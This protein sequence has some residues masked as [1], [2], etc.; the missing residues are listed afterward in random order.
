MELSELTEYACE[1]YQI[2]EQHKWADFPGFSVLCH[3]KTGKWVAL[4]MRQWDTDAGREIE[5]CDLKCGRESLFRLARPYL[6]API[7]MRGSKWIGI[8]F[9]EHTESDIV[10]QLFDKAIA[11]AEPQG[12][13]LILGAQPSSDAGTYRDTALPFSG[14]SYRPPR[15]KLPKR[16]WEMKRLYKYGSEALGARAENFYRQAVFMQDYEDDMP[17]TGDFV[18][19]FPTYQDLTTRQLRGYFA[20]RTQLRRGNYQRIA[21]S[22]AYIY[23]YELLNGV[24]AESPED[25]LKKMKEFEIAYLD[26]GIGNQRMRQH[27]RRWM[28]EYAVLRELPAETVFRMIEPDVLEKDRALS[29]LRRPEGHSD[30]EVFSALCVFEN[31][32]LQNSPVIALC[33]ERGKRL[34]SAAWRKAL[35]YRLHQKQL[36]TLCFGAKKTRRWYPLSNA[37]YCERERQADRNYVLNDNRR[38]RCRNGI[39]KVTAYEKLSFDR[40]RFHGFLHE[41]DARLRRCLKTGRYLKER[42]ADEWAIPYIDAVIEEDERAVLEAARP[43]LSLDLSG[44]ERIRRDA[45]GTRDSLLTEEEREV[46]GAVTGRESGMKTEKKEEPKPKREIKPETEPKSETEPEPEP[47]RRPKSERKPESK[48]KP[49]SER[50]PEIKTKTAVETAAEAVKAQETNGL[51]LRPAQVEILQA[52]LRGGD[53]SGILHANRLMPSIAADS[54]NEALFD[55][56]GDTVLRCEEDNLTLIADYIEEL[57]Q[58]LGGSDHG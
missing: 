28:L 44:L 29:V 27:L 2:R 8:A 52:L 5:R 48:R 56:I 24:G 42:P 9:E 39:W 12:Y 7:R 30:E 55:E 43:K 10:F 54:I 36:F 23:L 20:W 26:S 17:W 33:P 11:A 1:K 34:F 14:S 51:P 25:S 40:A 35:N 16:L 4:L 45:A 32:K 53:V 50:K 21:D 3:P 19:Y 41:T 37:V 49:E 58:L 13:T 38:Y 18:R 15:E 6:S 22:A 46:P 57:E 31:K 47:E